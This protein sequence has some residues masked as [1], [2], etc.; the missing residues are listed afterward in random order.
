[1][2]RPKNS[3]R[4]TYDLLPS[5]SGKWQKIENTAK[6]LLRRAGFK[7]IRTPIFEQTEIFQRAAGESSD[8]VNK[9]MYTFTDRSDRSITLRPEGTAGVVRAFLS[10]GLDRAPKPIKLWYYGPM[11][12][13]ERSQTGR[14]RQFTQLG[15]EV[16]GSATPE[17]EIE[18]I[19]LAWDLFQKLEIPDLTLEINSVGDSVSRLKYQE[20][21]RAFL[22]EHDSEICPDCINRMKT[23]P[24]RALDCKVPEDQ[25]LYKAKAPTISNYLNTAS[26]AHQERLFTLLKS[27][28]I[29]YIVNESLVR[30]L[31]Y[32]TKTVFEIKTDNKALGTQNTICAGGRYDGLVQEFGGP[33]TPAFGWALGMERLATLIEEQIKD[34]KL[35]YFPTFTEDNFVAVYKL[36]KAAREAGFSADI[37]YEG[38]NEK[39]QYESATKFAKVTD[40]IRFPLF[41]NTA[42]DI[43]NT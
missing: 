41:E 5:E 22:Q 13:Y 43:E 3:P 2:E 18:V 12:R 34:Q 16:F 36:I 30:G 21:M 25:A 10:N 40:Q 4:G 28:E 24:L 9:E 17:I 42:E 31:D 32:Y 20:A 35:D 14:Y 19:S 23:N 37:D 7:E 27:L 6:E 11:F 29:P 38:R 39:K 1:M 33:S 26:L 15:V 8:I